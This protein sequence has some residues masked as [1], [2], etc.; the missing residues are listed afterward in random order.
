[1]P[2]RRSRPPIARTASV[3]LWIRED[4]KWRLVLRCA[5]HRSNSLS[6]AETEL[7]EIRSA[8]AIFGLLDVDD[9]FFVIVRPAPAGYSVAAVGCHR[10]AGL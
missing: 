6:A 10:S 4:G 7:C 5:R 2:Q 3:W 9:E 1:M 8:G